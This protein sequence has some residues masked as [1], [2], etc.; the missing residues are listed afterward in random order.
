M[1]FSL[2][3]LFVE[4]HEIAYRPTKWLSLEIGFL[5]LPFPTFYQEKTFVINLNGIW[6]F[7]RKIFKPNFSTSCDFI[8]FWVGLPYQAL[9]TNTIIKISKNEDDY[10]VVIKNMTIEQL[11]DYNFVVRLG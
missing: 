2:Q 5:L 3:Q 9:S 1:P 6:N 4:A 8:D 11:S 10:R 7:Y